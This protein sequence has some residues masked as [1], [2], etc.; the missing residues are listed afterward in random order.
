MR[1]QLR[2]PCTKSKKLIIKFSLQRGVFKKIP[3][4]RLAKSRPLVQEQTL[5]PS[6][7]EGDFC[8]IITVKTN[9]LASMTLE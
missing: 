5:G 4:S 7:S 6:L 9:T 2:K 3:Q 1:E 8:F